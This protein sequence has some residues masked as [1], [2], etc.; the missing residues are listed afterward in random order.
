MELVNGLASILGMQGF[1][2]GP[3]QTTE[4]VSKKMVYDNRHG[5]HE[6]SV[7]E[8]AIWGMASVVEFKTLR[9]CAEYIL[10]V[11]INTL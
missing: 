6:G 1:P 7:Y 11:G 8:V 5:Y 10:K 3:K 2:H 9:E 4:I